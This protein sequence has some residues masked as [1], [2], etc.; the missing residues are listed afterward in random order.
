M[1]TYYHPYG[2][3]I[4]ELPEK[5]KTLEVGYKL[6]T[7]WGDSWRLNSGITSVDMEAIGLNKDEIL[8]EGASG[9]RYVVE[10]DCEGIASTYCAYVLADFIDNYGLHEVTFCDF[11]QSQQL[12]G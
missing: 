6:F 5:Y 10:R 4:L 3:V 1:A 11:K 12:N 7:D 8:F 9:S 2:W